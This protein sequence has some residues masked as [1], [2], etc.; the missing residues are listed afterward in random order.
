MGFVYDL[1]MT[2]QVLSVPALSV[3]PAAAAAAAAA[4]ASMT[5]LATVRRAMGRHRLRHGLPH[6]HAAA[7]TATAATA[8]AAAAVREGIRPEATA[9]RV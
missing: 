2:L 5:H 4:A 8:T 1:G 9:P 7:A 6:R 3:P